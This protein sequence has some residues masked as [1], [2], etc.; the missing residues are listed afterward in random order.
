MR[1]RSQTHDQRPVDMI[2]QVVQVLLVEDQ[3][4]PVQVLANG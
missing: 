1:R 2:D 4:E 3:P